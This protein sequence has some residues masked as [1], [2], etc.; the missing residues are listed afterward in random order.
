M[1]RHRLVVGLPRGEVL[2]LGDARIRHVG[3]AVVHH[4]ATLVIAVVGLL[5]EVQRAIPEAAVF[6]VEYASIGPVHTTWS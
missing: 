6:E 5:V 1:I 4:R 2:V 3:V